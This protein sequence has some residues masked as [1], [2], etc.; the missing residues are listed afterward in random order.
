MTN[1]LQTLDIMQIQE[2]LPYG[3]PFLLLDRVIDCRSGLS[4]TA[5]KNVTINE[6]FFQGHFF[7]RPI[8]PGVLIIE[9]MAQAG[10]ILYYMSSDI[11]QA[12]QLFYLVAVD[13]AKFRHSVFPGDRLQMDV[14][15]VRKRRNMW[16]FDCSANVDGKQVASA[17]IMCAPG[18]KE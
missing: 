17:I 6:P 16:R 13:N 3:Y 15:V 10:S 14:H 18:D 2:L 12:E 1:E 8:M 9:A 11:T 7:D 5:I 4:L